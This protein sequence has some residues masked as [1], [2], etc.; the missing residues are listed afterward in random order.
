MTPSERAVA[1]RAIAAMAEFA[2][3]ADSPEGLL[4]VDREAGLVDPKN[5]RAVRAKLLRLLQWHRIQWEAF[6]SSLP[7]RSWVRE[8]VD[9][10]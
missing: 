10:L 7:N 4:V 9:Q 3:L 8:S 6:M 5:P 1:V 2:R